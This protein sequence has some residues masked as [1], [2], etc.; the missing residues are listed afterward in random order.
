MPVLSAITKSNA[1]S[2]QPSPKVVRIS[3]LARIL[4]VSTSTIHRM[5]R[6]DC[7]FPKPFR[8]SIQAVGFDSAEVD[9]WI[10]SRKANRQ[11]RE[12]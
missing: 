9:A 5:R 11:A 2:S 7:H 12:V 1:T 6:Q 10:E 3:A 8:I 4:G